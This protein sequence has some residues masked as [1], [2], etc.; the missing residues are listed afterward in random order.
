[1]GPEVL[2]FCGK[3][4]LTD[5]H[6]DTITNP[7]VIVEILSPST[8][9]YDYGG[10]FSLYRR[11]PSF[12]EYILFSQDAALVETF[13]KTHD[14]EWVLRTHEGLDAV[15][16]IESLGI[17]LPLLRS[18]CRRRSALWDVIQLR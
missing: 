16:A 14:S 2:V 3:A 9:D 10:K 7:K 6:H 15:V 8:A 13:R 4:A 17:S 11:L 12:E 18:V 1:V 5:E